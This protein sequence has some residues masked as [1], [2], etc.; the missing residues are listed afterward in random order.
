MSGESPL[1][2]ASPYRAPGDSSSAVVVAAELGDQSLVVFAIRTVVFLA[3]LAGL[4]YAVTMLLVWA[5]YWATGVIAPPRSIRGMTMVAGAFGSVVAT[6]TTMSAV[7]HR[8]DVLAFAA[9][10]ASITSA[11]IVVLAEWSM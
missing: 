4:A 10:L 11:L 5:W 7:V 1:T 3:A 9:G 2:A 8:S 6:G